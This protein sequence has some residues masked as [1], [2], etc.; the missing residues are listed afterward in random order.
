MKNRRE[1]MLTLTAGLVALAVVITPVIAEEL[2][3]VITK[4]EDGGKKLTVE[5]KEDGKEVIVT[6]NGDTESSPGRGTSSSRTLWRSSPALCRRSR[7]RGRKGLPAK[8]THEKGVASKIAGHRQEEGRELRT[9]DGPVETRSRV[10]GR[11]SPDPPG[12]L[13]V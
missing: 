6:T 2:L 4:I 9:G 13:G 5:S 12:G 7:T 3:G 10:R 8:V 1:F 11:V